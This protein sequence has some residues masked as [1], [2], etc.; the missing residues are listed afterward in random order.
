MNQKIK[1]TAKEGVIIAVILF[2]LIWVC[3]R[4]V[5][6]G[7]VE[8]TDNAQVR[9]QIVPV[10]CRVQGFI[11]K[12]NFT[13]Y[14]TVHKGDT[15]VI[16]E[17]TEFRLRL[18]QAEADYQNA[19]TGKSAMGTTISTAQNNISVSDAG[20]EEIRAL[21]RNSENDYERYKNLLAKK[22]VTQ[23]QYDA[24]KSSWTPAGCK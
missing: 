12:I 15:L 4:F 18:A 23:Q 5:H 9:Q 13:E 14:Q 24:V 11:R 1:K 2:G 3:S 6:L 21:L 8:F 20:I 16:I 22:A 17:N 7:Q 10:N 19:L